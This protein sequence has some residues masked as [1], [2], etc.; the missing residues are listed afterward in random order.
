MNTFELIPQKLVFGGAALGYHAGQAVLAPL[1]LPGERV[2][3]EPVRSAKGMVHARLLRVLESAPERTTPLCPYFGDCGGCQYQHLSSEKAL[4][5]KASILRETLRRVGK[6]NWEQEIRVRS[7][8]PWSYRNQA[9]LKVNIR[10]DGMAGL[11]FFAA[12]SH[13][14]V[15]IE[16]CRIISPRLNETLAG[17]RQALQPA[18]LKGCGEITMMADDEDRRVMLTFAGE[19]DAGA[20]GNIAVETLKLIPWVQT[21]AFAM[22][23]AMD[24]CGEPSLTYQAASFRY[25]ISPG[26]FFQASRFLIPGLV[27]AV[28][29]TIIGQGSAPGMNSKPRQHY[30]SRQREMG[31]QRVALDL[32]AGCGLFALPLA[33]QYD[34]VMAVEAHAGS[35]RDLAASARAHGLRNLNAV[36]GPVHEFLR[37]FAGPTPGLV[38]LDPP[39]TGV[40][41]PSLRLLA[42]LGAAQLCYVSCHPPTL[43]RD[44]NYLTQHGYRLDSVE[45]FDLFPQTHHIESIARLTMA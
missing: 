41:L 31:G 27:D 19:M 32:Y 38:V 30:G 15:E 26:S 11:G 29:Q 12:E 4:E 44:L 39:R 8:F 40:N 3:V 16:N 25:Q 42:S 7:A 17:L 45:M 14:L 9:H 24:T 23:D 36:H 22:R 37:R 18:W 28:T 21:V 13:R 43:A 35:A 1:A 20:R 6:I 5:W 10:A 34:L 2:E 33:R